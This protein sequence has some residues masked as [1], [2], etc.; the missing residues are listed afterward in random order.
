MKRSER[1]A[2]LRFLFVSKWASCDRS[3][4]SGDNAEIHLSIQHI[5]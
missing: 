5:S 1:G 2:L 3:V 4:L